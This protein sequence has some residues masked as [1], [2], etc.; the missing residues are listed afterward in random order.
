M[1]GTVAAVA[2]AAVFV[3]AAVAK[4]RAPVAT[5]QAFRAM[6]IRHS[7]LAARA[8]PVSELAVAAALVASPRG[9]GIVA[10]VALAAMSTVLVV[11]IRGGRPVPCACFGATRIRPT[12]T[13]DLVRNVALMALAV[14]AI[15]V[16]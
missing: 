1:L 2:L 5:A 7:G 6:R 15:V 14:V 3:W 8:V 16:S 4:L 11:V 9:G 10:L 13:G 12:G